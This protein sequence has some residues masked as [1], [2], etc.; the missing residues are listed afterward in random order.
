MNV[1]R[2]ETGEKCASQ[3][4]NNAR[5][6]KTHSRKKGILE[7]SYSR[8]RHSRRKYSKQFMVW[9]WG[10]EGLS[11]NDARW[12]IRCINILPLVWRVCKVGAGTLV[13]FPQSWIRLFRWW[14]GDPIQIHY[15]SRLNRRK[16]GSVWKDQS[17]GSFHKPGS[18]ASYDAMDEHAGK[19]SF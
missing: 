8:K 11:E 15:Q 14:L 7:K 19:S 6:K 13:Y 18:I 3:S 4:E 2:C 1:G 12:K 5:W 16:T 10:S 9:R 17:A